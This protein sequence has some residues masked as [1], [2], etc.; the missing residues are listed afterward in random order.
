MTKRSIAT[1]LAAMFAVA[2]LLVF[3][4][5][6]GALST[7][8]HRELDRHQVG[9]LDTKLVYATQMIGRCVTHEKWQNVKSKLDTLTPED[10]ST[11]FFVSSTDSRFTYG[12][13]IDAS[14]R[15]QS[16]LIPAQ[17]ERPAV[18]LAVGIDSERFAS[19]L[20]SFELSLIG[21]CSLG[22]ALVALLGYR[23]AKVGLGPVQELSKEA[24][25]LSPR[26]LTQRLNLSPMPAEIADLTS[27]FN[28]AL[29]RLERAYV[30]LEAFNADVAHE[31]RTP[32]AN[33]IGQTQVVLSKERSAAE[34]VETLQSNLEELERVRMIVNDMLFLARADQ[35]ETAVNRQRTSVRQEIQKTLEF[36]EMILDDAGVT[37]R[38]AGDAD[39]CIE[40]SLFRRAITNLIQNAVQHTQRG[41]EIVVEVTKQAPHVRVVVANPGD[42]IPAQH[43][44]R[45]FDRFYRVDAAR[46]NESANHGLGLS[47]VKAIALMHGGGVFAESAAGQTA[48][49]FTI[50]ES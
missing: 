3:A 20:R 31:L 23:I 37:V 8:L 43:L 50:A 9:E 11:Q 10:Q 15:T 35:G 1:R 13:P 5:V 46:Q 41:Q 29:D 14:M 36:L 45:L 33:L 49:G 18:R 39:A 28:G 21:L 42:L 26:N 25:L 47:I 38:I 40:V 24:S 17:N 16:T 12:A 19:T 44:P 30:Q 2:A 27:T 22:V 32:I 4:L 48:V 6:G 7:V 34:L